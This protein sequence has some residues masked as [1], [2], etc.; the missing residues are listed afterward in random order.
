MQYEAPETLEAATALLA[1]A[2]GQARVLA[3]G[4]DLVLLTDMIVAADDTVIGFPPTRAMGSPPA[5]RQ[6]WSRKTG[7]SLLP[8]FS[9]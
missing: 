2:G 7:L 1:G 8:T 5:H 6:P 3:G 9:K 4:T